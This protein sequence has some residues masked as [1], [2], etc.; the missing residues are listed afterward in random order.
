MP[1][2]VSRPTSLT[3]AFSLLGAFVLAL[4]PLPA[5]G[6]PQPIA[7]E[8]VA[9]PSLT[10]WHAAIVDTVRD[11]MIVYGGFMPETAGDVWAFDLVTHRWRSMSWAPYGSTV[12]RHGHSAIYD[13]A[14]DRMVTYGGAA[15]EFGIIVSGGRS[16]SLGGGA[17]PELPLPVAPRDRFRHVGL[18][19]AAR[20]EMIV[21]GGAGQSSTGP[22]DTVY[23]MSLA[24]NTRNPANIQRSAA[25]GR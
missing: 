17:S 21:L 20:D 24:T 19:D 2:L 8:V 11:Q 12:G 16:F 18:L 14:R 4:A 13:A 23:R 9:P 6:A 22:A 25:G 1:P 3:L 5:Q 10:Y 15:P 7:W